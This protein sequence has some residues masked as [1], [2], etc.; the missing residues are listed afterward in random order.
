MKYGKHLIGWIS[1]C[2]LCQ[3]ALAQPQDSLI[4]NLDQSVE[5]A[6]ENNPEVQIAEKELAKARAGIWEAYAAILPSINGSASFQKSWEIQENTIPNFIKVM[7]GPNFPGVEAMPDYVKL[8]FGLENTFMYG[9]SLTQPLFLGGAGVAGVQMAYAAKDAS[10]H[11]L[12]SKRQNLIYQ[13]VGA[14]YGCLLAKELVDVQTQAMAQARANLDAV[15]K[16]YEAGSASGF[17]KMRAEVEA[18]NI[19]PQKIAA[20][21]DYQA[22]LTGFRT[23]LGLGK[24]TQLDVEGVL[25][26]R[27][28]EMDGVTLQELQTTSLNNR[29]EL[30]AFSAQKRIASKGIAVAR[31]QFMPKIFFSTDY[32]FLAMTNN[33]DISQDDFSKGFTSAVSLRIPLFNGFKNH[34]QYQKARLDYK[35]TL[36]AEKQIRDGI[37]AEVELAYNKFQEA[38]EKYQAARESTGLAEEA[39]RMANLMYE[40]GAS[41]QLDVMSSQLALT[42]ARLNYASA[43]YEYQMARYE[44]RRVSGTLQGVL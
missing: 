40:E 11:Q 25:E 14:F 3:T 23:V 35:I 8:S 30:A 42:R 32:S 39:L 12:E 27:I 24:E 22:A 2:L 26:F 34:K 41:T 44:L 38:K 6:L 16:K 15:V 7:L 17:D 9:A 10:A 43:L 13:T 18:A 21:N 36:D 5:L 29:P 19:L 4:L 37:A 31:S 1:A 20:E 33:Y 28:D